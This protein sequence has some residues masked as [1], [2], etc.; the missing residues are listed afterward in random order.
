MAEPQ[1]RLATARFIANINEVAYPIHI[2]CPRKVLNINARA[3]KFRYDRNFLLQF[4]DVCKEKPDRLPPLETFGL[5]GLSFASARGRRKR[6][7]PPPSQQPLPSEQLGTASSIADKTEDRCSTIV[8]DSPANELKPE[9]AQRAEEVRT[10]A[11][12]ERTCRQADTMAIVEVRYLLNSLFLEDFDFLSDLVIIWANSSEGEDDAWTLGEVV[13]LVFEQAINEPKSSQLCARLCCKMVEQVS[14]AVAHHAIRDTDGQPIVG[15]HLLRKLLLKRCQDL[16]VDIRRVRSD[17]F[18]AYAVNATSASASDVLHDEMHRKAHHQIPGLVQLVG[19]LFKL[20]M[21][22][23]HIMHEC[24]D[25]LLRN[26]DDPD[27]EDIESLCALLESVGQNLDTTTISSSKMDPFYGLMKDLI[28]ESKLDSC[29]RTML[30]EVIALRSR[31]WI[32]RDIVAAPRIIQ[33][34]LSASNVVLTR[35]LGPR[36]RAGLGWPVMWT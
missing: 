27:E 5:D 29:L 6:V 3:G 11:V 14:P 12:L 15:G 28:D 34:I 9:E 30:L 32:P 36:Y 1:S 18:L 20:Q 21:L 35:G 19:E 31:N 8:I 10:A 16:F 33:P 24:V 25:M 26:I 7:R 22:T 17:D 4:R 13:R 2:K 23:E